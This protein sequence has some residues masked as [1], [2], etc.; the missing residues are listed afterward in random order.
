MFKLQ[1]ETDN[2]AFN[3]PTEGERYEIARILEAVRQQVLFGHTVGKLMDI[4]GN[5]VGTFTFKRSK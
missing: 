1:M 2:E 3:S 5:S 4:N